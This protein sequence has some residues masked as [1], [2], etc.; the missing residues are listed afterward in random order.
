MLRFEWKE[1]RLASTITGFLILLQSG[2]VFAAPEAEYL[3]I[4]APNAAAGIPGGKLSWELRD[5][6]GSYFNYRIGG[7]D[8]ASF[9]FREEEWMVHNLTSDTHSVSLLLDWHP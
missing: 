2:G 9:R 3:I 5:S 6:L 7:N 1:M 8:Q 4:G